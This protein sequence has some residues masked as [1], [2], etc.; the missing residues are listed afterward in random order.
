MLYSK[1]DMTSYLALNTVLTALASAGE[2]TRLRLLALLTEAELT[3]SELV[4]I[5]GQSQPRISRHLKLLT[6]AGLI[7]RHREGA[8]AFFSA[9]HRTPVTDLARTIVGRLDPADAVLLADR[10]RLAEVRAA[11][12]ATAER[13]FASQATQWDRLRSLHIAEERVEAAVLEAV[14]PG[15]FHALLDLGTGTGRMLEL[16]GSRASRAIGIDQSHAM[17]N[18]ARSRVERTGHRNIQVRQGD[19]YAL[20]VERDGYDLVVLHQ[21]LHF[22]DDPSR[23]LREAARAL[24]PAG[25]LI[26]V[27]FAPHDDEALRTNH[28]HRRLGFAGPE[29]EE[30]MVQAGLRVDGHRDLTPMPGEADK[31]TVSIWVGRDPRLLSDAHPAFQ[32][33]EV[34]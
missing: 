27:D 3:V 31:L 4:T 26:V 19:L 13:Y 14:G 29:V 6:E 20:P 12:K 9:A 8:W 10:A 25:R 1:T 18:I 33:Q 30:F 21:V 7:E 34:A 24:R 16:L 28:A 23:A 32:R 15:P 11:R 17:L 22:L 2:E 5:L